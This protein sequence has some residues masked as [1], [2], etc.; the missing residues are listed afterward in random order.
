MPNRHYAMQEMFTY[1]LI[2]YRSPKEQR[3]VFPMQPLIGHYFIVATRRLER[4]YSFMVL[5]AAS[6]SQLSNSLEQQ[7]CE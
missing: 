1:C 5:Q 7:A 6:E 3:S 4:R 2:T